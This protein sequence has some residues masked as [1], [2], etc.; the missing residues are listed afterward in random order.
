MRSRG[1]VY[2]WITFSDRDR[3]CVDNSSFSHAFVDNSPPER[4]PAS[5]RATWGLLG[6]SCSP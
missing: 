1:T 3:L 4:Y 5:S 2:A 6:L